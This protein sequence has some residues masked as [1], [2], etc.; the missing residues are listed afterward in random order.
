MRIQR[1]NDFR[2]SVTLFLR[3]GGLLLGAWVALAPMFSGH[4]VHASV[5]KRDTNDPAMRVMIVGSSVADGWKDTGGGYL[6]RTFDRLHHSFSLPID[7]INRA[8]PGAPATS[9]QS[10]YTGWLD[11]ARPQVVV[12]AWGGLDDAHAGTPVPLFA[13]LIHNQIADALRRGSAV[14]MV[15][16]PISRASYTQYPVLQQAYMTAEVNV[17][18][19]FASPRV[20]V[21]NVF[22]QM[23]QYLLIHH[24]TYVPFM[25]DGWHPN[26]AGHKLAASILLRDIFH[27][28][29]L[30]MLFSQWDGS[31]AP[32]DA[33]H[34]HGNLPAPPTN[35]GS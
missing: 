13:S 26:T 17:A 25:A 23:K 18:K 35:P 10:Q 22:D 32:L 7:W 29:R 20:F 2:R 14:F 21:F 4:T 28:H 15:T 30:R 11:S 6:W 3:V 9:L 12:L 1:N 16:T 34:P 31:L 27:N 5:A 33:Y 19:S 24:L 8:V